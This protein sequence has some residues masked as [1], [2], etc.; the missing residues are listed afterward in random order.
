MGALPSGESPLTGR[1][2][3]GST[4]FRILL[5]GDSNT[6]GFVEGGTRFVPYGESLRTQLA[7]A[8]IDCKISWCGLCA[9][10]AQEMADRINAPFIQRRKGLGIDG[11]G[12]MKCLTK[13]GGYDLVI[14]MAGTNDL[15]YGGSP[16]KALQGIIRLHAA[17]HERGI[18][19]VAIAPSF[20]KNR[21]GGQYDLRKVLA[22]ALEEY[23]K[24][25][26][27]VLDFA[28]IEALLPRHPRSPHWDGDMVHM[29]ALGNVV[30]GERLAEKL[31]ATLD[32]LETSMEHRGSVYSSEFSDGGV[33]ARLKHHASEKMIDHRRPAIQIMER[34]R[35]AEFIESPTVKVRQIKRVASFRQPQSPVGAS[36]RYAPGCSPRKTVAMMPQQRSHRVVV[37]F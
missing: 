15:L 22:S 24:Q 10:T 25:T 31:E 9:Y 35:S 30:F 37:A 6:A 29:T 18:P 28:D 11:K 26:P 7:S 17:C 34:H 8:G 2:D 5:Y 33:V 21:R 13:D 4:K 14:I 16:Q 23:A 36:F 19:T 27:D 12:L 32:D 20:A 3:E 1:Q